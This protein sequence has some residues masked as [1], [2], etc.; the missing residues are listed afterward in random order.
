LDVLL[1]N[2]GEVQLKKILGATDFKALK[3][4]VSYNLPNALKIIGKN[5]LGICNSFYAAKWW[6]MDGAALW[7]LIG[8]G[9]ACR[10]IGAPDTNAFQERV[11]SEVK[12]FLLPRRNRYGIRRSL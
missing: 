5:F 4:K 12:K 2:I 10:Y 3:T 9:V 1:E 7:L 6:K 11:L 8:E